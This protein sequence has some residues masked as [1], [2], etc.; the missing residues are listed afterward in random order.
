MLER[1]G[2]S[3]LCGPPTRRGDHNSRSTHIQGPRVKACTPF[4]PKKTGS[5]KQ[6]FKSLTWKVQ[7]AVEGRK[8]GGP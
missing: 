3:D 2:P 4:P 1:I 7:E 5:A 6:L 8:R